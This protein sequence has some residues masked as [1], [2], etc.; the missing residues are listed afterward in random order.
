MGGLPFGLL[1]E[2]AVAGLLALTIGYCVVLNG[3]LKRL[4]ADR[5]VLRQMVTDLVRATDMAHGAIRS[6]KETAQ[7]ADLALTARLESAERFGIE[8]AGHVNAGQAVLDR[9]SRITQAARPRTV[10]EAEPA[11]L[12]LEAALAQLSANPRM[13]GHAA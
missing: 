1:M 7:E 6:L 5:E 11:E 13:R 9:I 2:S 10:E 12:R 4:Q 3:R 8:L